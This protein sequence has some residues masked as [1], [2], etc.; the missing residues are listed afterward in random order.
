[1]YEGPRRHS[2]SFKIIFSRNINKTKNKKTWRT[3]VLLDEDGRRPYWFLPYEY[4]HGVTV[5]MSQ[6]DVLNQMILIKT[7]LLAA[8][9]AKGRSKM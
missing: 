6:D 3:D 7:Q 4:E 8:A 1:M 9:F 2:E 5:V